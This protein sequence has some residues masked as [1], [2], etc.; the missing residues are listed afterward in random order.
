M[1]CL[2]ACLHFFFSFFLFFLWKFHFEWDRSFFYFRARCCNM[3]YCLWGLWSSKIKILFYAVDL[4]IPFKLV[5]SLV[6]SLL[7][8]A[9]PC[10]CRKP[11]WKEKNK[12]PSL[13][14]CYIGIVA[15]PACTGILSAVPPDFAQY[16]SINSQNRSFSGNSLH[17][18]QYNLAIYWCSSFSKLHA[19]NNLT[20]LQW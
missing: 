18:Q 8:G 13:Q 7:A 15:Q 20:V 14:K 17:R 4:L 2:L 3:D 12:S 16:I 6:L 19:S 10:D 1:S 11:L 5:F 9:G